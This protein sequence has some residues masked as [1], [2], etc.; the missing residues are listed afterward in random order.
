MSDSNPTVSL[1]QGACLQLIAPH[2]KDFQ[3]VLQCLSLEKLALVSTEAGTPHRCLYDITIS[4]GNRFIKAL[5]NTELNTLVET[6][7]LT[8]NSIFT[9]RSTAINRLQNTRC[10]LDGLPFSA[11]LLSQIIL[12][13]TAFWFFWISSP[14][15]HITARSAP[16][17]LSLTFLLLCIPRHQ[18]LVYSPHFL[19]LQRW[20]RSHQWSAA[21]MICLPHG[22]IGW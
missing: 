10:V 20:A 19:W 16:Q 12:S 13:Y 6:S 1:T 21:S 5:L 4:D 8:K 14:S 7:L 15:S 3:P 17:S 11:S 18:N 22:P 9:V 2:P